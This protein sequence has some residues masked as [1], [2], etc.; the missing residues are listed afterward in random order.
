MPELPEVE[1]VVR[2]LRAVLPGRRIVSVR[3]GKTDFMD[4][5]D[6]LAAGLPGT[7]FANI[8]RRGKFILARL[9]AES[10]GKAAA[11]EAASYLIVHLGMTGRLLVQAAEIPAMPHTHA[12][13]ALDDGRELRYVDPRRFG[14]MAFFSAAQFDSAFAG[15]GAEP[16][17]ISEAE[18]RR[19]LAGR[20]AMVKAL[21]LDQHFLR[22]I[23][24]IYA[25]ESL[26][27]AKLHPQRLGARLGS[28]EAHRLLESFRH[29]LREAI[30]LGGSSISDFVDAN[31]VAGEFQIR[32]RVY[33]REGKGC[34]RCGAKIRRIIVAGRSSYF[35]PRCQPAPRKRKTARQS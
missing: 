11:N 35:C 28:T 16:L 15:L 19:L 24:N 12:F 29:V 7:R 18:F 34:F 3:L 26:W 8:Q 31:G 4:D 10:G 32:H 17:E 1:T 9:N 30:R 14:R 25:D 33:D 2:G 20:R 13:F 21:L 23:G 6:A 5:P 22:G 27:R